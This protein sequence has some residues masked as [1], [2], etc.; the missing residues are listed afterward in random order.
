MTL[1][2][3]MKHTEHEMSAALLGCV[4]FLGDLLTNPSFIDTF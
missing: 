3:E 1:S 2:A 4:V